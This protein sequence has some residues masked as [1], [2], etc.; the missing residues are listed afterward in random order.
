[1]DLNDFITRP[2]SFEYVD[3]IVEK[4]ALTCDKYEGLIPEL[5]QMVQEIVAG[6]MPKDHFSIVLRIV[7]K[8]SKH[9]SDSPFMKELFE[10]IQQDF[11]HGL[12]EKVPR[13]KGKYYINSVG[14]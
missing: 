2:L 9:K 4:F 6:P 5:D 11:L 8:L 14:D 12:N 13:H 7:E 10:N 3:T 1:M